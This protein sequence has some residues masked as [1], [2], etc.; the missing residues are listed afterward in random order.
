MEYLVI[1]LVKILDP[2]VAILA[3]I[4]ILFSRKIIII[5][6][7]AAI[8]TIIAEQILIAT[9]PTYLGNKWFITFAASF[10][11]ATLWYFLKS[12]LQKKMIRRL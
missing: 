2:I 1:L 6:I 12:K 8:S 4:V 10:I 9:S 11:W 3:L 7:S 5:P